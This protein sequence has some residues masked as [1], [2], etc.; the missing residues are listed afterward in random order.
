MQKFRSNSWKN[1]KPETSYN[2]YIL[3]YKDKKISSESFFY[4]DIKVRQ[5]IV[6][7]NSNKYIFGECK[8]FQLLASFY[9][10][11]NYSKK[12]GIFLCKYTLGFIAK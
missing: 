1:S 8:T 6:T 12:G 2:H 11:N 3:Q 5:V 7:S 10:I 4:R 9:S